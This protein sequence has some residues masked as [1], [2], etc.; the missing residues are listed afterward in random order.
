MRE[1]DRMAEEK[2]LIPS[3]I[4]MENAGRE[5]VEAL[6]EFCQFELKNRKIWV[7]CGPGNNGGDGFVVARHLR[8]EK[9]NIKV[10][11]LAEPEKLRGD[12]KLNYEILKRIG[13]EV[14]KI[15]SEN[16]IPSFTPRPDIIIDAIFGT[17]FKGKPEGLSARVIELVNNSGSIVVA[18]DIPSGVSESGK[19]EGVAIKADLT[20]TMG[21]IK[22]S[23]L[24][25]P[26]KRHCGKLY[27]ANIGIPNSHFLSQGD[28]FLLEEDDIKSLLPR[29]KEDGNKGTFGKVLV[30]AGSAG[31]SGAASLTAIAAL[32]IGCGLVRLA[33]LEE[34][35]PALEAK[36]TEVVKIPLPQKERGTYS[37]KM[38]EILEN[39]IADSDVFAIGP[40]IGTKEETKEFL[41]QFLKRIQKPVVIDA[42]GVNNLA[43]NIE[44]LT[45]IKVPIILTPHPGELGR[46]INCSPKTINENRIEIAKDFASKYQVILL[47]KGAPTILA[48]PE[49]KVFVNPTGN[50][51]LAS[52]GTG[53]VL[54]G[55]IAGILAQGANP[56]ESAIAGAYI[57]GLCADIGV[58][59]KTEYAFIASDILE[60]LPKAILRLAG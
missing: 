14:I 28:K 12:A 25:F 17:G 57:H 39:Y 13:Q 59:E 21:F 18:I 31:F 1:I 47:L 55:F 34:V 4:L 5:V 50:S 20:V 11:L 52:G 51:G 9:S 30:V 26:G 58:K 48:S 35:M 40:G 56:L 60:Y 49:G 3:C 29:R 6:K 19:V 37:V 23:L 15:T 46:L 10:F 33:S 53:D 22:D 43:G 44:I 2:F 16:D 41:S 45:E 38:L 24:L 32:R 36:L 27:V 8:N 54:T 7:F 42:D